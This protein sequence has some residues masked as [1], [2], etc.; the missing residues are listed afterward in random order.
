MNNAFVKTLMEKKGR[1]SVLLMTHPGIELSGL[2]VID[3][4]TKGQDH[5]K[6]I[7]AI[8]KRCP[9]TDA[10]T[11]MMDLTVEAE[12]FGAALRFSDNEQPSV[13][14]RLLENAG[15]VKDLSVP[16]LSEG[17]IP[18][19]LKACSM[20]AERI[21]KPVLAGAIGPFSLAGRLFGMTEIMIAL[22]LEPDTI[23]EL[24]EKCTCFIL[25]YI[26]AI[27][28]TGAAGVVL[29]EPA[30]GLL[31]NDD[32][33]KFSSV[34]VRKIVD[35]CQDY[36]F[37]VVLHNCGNSGNCTE[38]MIK[39]GAGALHF[40]NRMNMLEALKACPSDMLVMGNLDPVGV[41]RYGDR[42]TVRQALVQLI[43]ETK[44]YGNFII[45][46][47]CDIPPGVPLENIDEFYEVI[48]DCID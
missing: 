13:E 8:Y 21:D 42:E 18:E 40:G 39:T 38:A 48:K 28:K 32:C 17:R 29:A 27:K 47:G 37:A 12:A 31:S 30:A 10:V 45:S 2:K 16:S 20:A 3:A 9:D 1:K 23:I 44:G 36:S 22:Y 41:F 33:M 4:V 11:T 35:R 19:Y 5:F 34:F 43:N 6:A 14:G 7:E 46:S 25:E 26:L 24:L 15:D